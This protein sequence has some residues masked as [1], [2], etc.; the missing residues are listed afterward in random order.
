MFEVQT[1]EKFWEQDMSYDHEISAITCPA[2]SY[3]VAGLVYRMSS[4]DDNSFL[5]GV[6]KETGEEVWESAC[7]AGKD[8]FETVAMKHM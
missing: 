1:G 7:P 2:V 4:G 3:I 8:F 5:I 6:D